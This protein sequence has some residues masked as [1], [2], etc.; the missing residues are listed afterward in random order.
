MYHQTTSLIAF[1]RRFIIT[2]PPSRHTSKQPYLLTAPGGK[3]PSPKKKRIN[4]LAYNLTVRGDILIENGW[5]YEM[6]D[7][8]EPFVPHKWRR[9]RKF[10]LVDLKK[11]SKTFYIGKPVHKLPPLGGPK[12]KPSGWAW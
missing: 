4:E 10:L 12:H 11:V 6:I 3:H 5:T 8:L 1:T 2:D 7:K 9:K